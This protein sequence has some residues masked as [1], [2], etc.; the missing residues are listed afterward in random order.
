L[1]LQAYSPPTV[2][3]SNSGLKEFQQP[4]F[5]G[6]GFKDNKSVCENS[7]NEI[8]KTTDALI[9]KDWVFDCD[10]DDYEVM[11]LKSDNVQHKPEQANQPKK[12][13]QNLR[14]KNSEIRS[15]VS[16]YKESLFCVWE[17]NFVPTAVLTKS[18]IVPASAVRPINTV[19]PKSF[20]N[21]ENT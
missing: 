1:H 2:D 15:W 17:R 16:D 21:V 10:G 14:N 20:V 12:V 3:L 13:S 9:I 4:E 11:V 7:L 8:K 19:A 6:Y 5:E 18:G